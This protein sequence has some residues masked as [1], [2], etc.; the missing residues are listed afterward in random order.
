[1]ETTSYLTA[2]LSTGKIRGQPAGQTTLADHLALIRGPDL[3]GFTDRARTIRQKMDSDVDHTE[4]DHRCATCLAYKAAKDEG[5]CVTYGGLWP[6]RRRLVQIGKDFQPSGLVFV[7]MEGGGPANRDALSPLPFVA[8]AYVSLSGAGVHTVSAVSPVPQTRDEYRAAW[9]AICVALGVDADQAVRLDKSAKD[10]TRWAVAPHDP[11]AYLVKPEELRPFRWQDGDDRVRHAPPGSRNTTLNEEAYKAALHAAPVAGA[12]Q[13]AQDAGLD[14]EE[15]ASTV[16][17]AVAGGERA[18][19]TRM[20]EIIRPT[21]L[22]AAVASPDWGARDF[23]GELVR[24]KADQLMVVSYDMKPSSTNPLGGRDALAYVVNPKTGMWAHDPVLLREWL[25]EIGRQ[26]VVDA[27]DS[28]ET[29]DASKALRQA[30]RMKESAVN[31]AIRRI[32]DVQRG[33]QQRH[34][35]CRCGQTR[36]QPVGVS[37]NGHRRGRISDRQAARP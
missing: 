26:V 37:G 9:R 6:T 17:S 18:R 12:A 31:E 36:A 28:L 27:F 22:A 7:E 32:P 21:R 2:T 30:K 33:S 10:T 20:R 4:R 19:E 24:R 1:M 16:A 11:D 35:P 25:T 29:T 15:V 23:S 8:A 5:R 14:S 3:A 34:P 13:A